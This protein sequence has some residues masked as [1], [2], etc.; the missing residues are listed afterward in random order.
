MS[1]IYRNVNEWLRLSSLQFIHV[2]K[3]IK[4]LSFF[5][6]DLQQRLGALDLGGAS[7]QI[8]FEV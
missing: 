7:T 6:E 5:Q 2:T 4:G 3:M 1:N 8:A